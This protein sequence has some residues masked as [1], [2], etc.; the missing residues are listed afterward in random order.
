M[1]QKK[2]GEVRIC[3]DLKALNESVL[4]EV[5]PNPKVDETLAQ[6]AGACV[7]SKFDANNGFWQIPLAPKS[8]P[9][10]T[11]ITPFGRYHFNKLLFGISSAPELFQQRM[12]RIL[13]GIPGVFF[14]I[15]DVIVFGASQEEHDQRLEAALC[16]IEK[17][18]VT[19][20][21]AK[22]EF[23]KASIQYLGCIIDHNGIRADP[24]KTRAI[25][26]VEA[27][28]SVSDLRRV[29]GMANHLGKFSP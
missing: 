27:P 18:K 12:S 14:Q 9:L 8:R 17:A 28:Q 19:L 11:F 22:C 6:L 15:D 23:S 4:R 26:E 3:V 29:L 10:T 20:N 2:S 16:R 5:H 21:P 13:E 25:L 1:F 7:F 24:M